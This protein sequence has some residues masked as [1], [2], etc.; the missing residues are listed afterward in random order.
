M[1]SIPCGRVVWIL[2]CI[3]V[4]PGS[5]DLSTAQMSDSVAVDY[6]SIRLK[7]GTVL[8]GPVL[9]EDDGQITVEAQ[10]ASG[11]IIHKERVEKSNIASL[12]HLSPADRDQR[13]A[14]IAYHGLAKYQLDSQSSLPPAYYDLAINEGF[15]PFLQKYPQAMESATVSN[16][17]AEWKSER[18]MVA[19]GQIKYRGKW[20]TTDEADKL[21]AS[22]RA[23]QVI[24]DARALMA[25]G[26]FDAATERLAPYYSAPQSPQLAVESRRLQGDVYRLWVSSLQTFKDQ[27]GKDLEASKDRVARLA[28]ARSKAQSDY[29]QARAKNQGSNVRTLGDAAISG[30]T[31]ADYFRAEKQFGDEQKRESALQQQLDDTVQKLRDVQQSQDLF[32]TAY[33]PM[34]LVKETPPPRTN[35]VPP[36]PPPPP[37]TFLEKAGEWFGRNWIMAVGVGLL[38]MW[39]ISRLLTR[40]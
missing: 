14:T 37:P 13:L 2:L 39:G 17:L 4:L 40:A 18:S 5:I 35:A 31:A 21:T 20:M 30:Q 32:A 26:Q 9:L 38:G 34:E 22:E 1:K 11:T 28:E 27:L 8:E 29:D 10:A 24:Q 25:Q 19:S 16:R 33:P 3:L 15:L 6:V 12:S 23:Q 36:P 7:D